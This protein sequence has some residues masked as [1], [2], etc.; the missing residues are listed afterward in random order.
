MIMN[1]YLFYFLL[2]LYFIVRYLLGISVCLELCI[3]T[4]L[5]HFFYIPQQKFLKIVH[6]VFEKVL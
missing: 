4:S 1:V 2:N 5:F 6:E 3:H